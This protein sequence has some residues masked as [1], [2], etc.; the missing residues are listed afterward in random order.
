MFFDYVP[1]A[2]AAA[3]EPAHRIAMKLIKLFEL[4]NISSATL[5]AKKTI[6]SNLFYNE[7]Y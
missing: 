2:A 6:K 4:V 5:P 7:I 1:S 3:E